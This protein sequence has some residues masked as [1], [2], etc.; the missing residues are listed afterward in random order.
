MALHPV[1]SPSVIESEPEHGTLT[2]NIEPRAWGE[3]GSF[4]ILVRAGNLGEL[5]STEVN[6]R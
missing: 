6:W 4:R 5:A 2:L 1:A 3:L